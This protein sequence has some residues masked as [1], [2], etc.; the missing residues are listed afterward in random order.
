MGANRPVY[1]VVAMLPCLLVAAGIWFVMP[2]FQQVFTNFNAPLPLL[3][4]VVMATHRWWA[5]SALLP[6][7]VWSGWPPT[8]DR[9]AAAV[10]CGSVLAGVMVTVAVLACYLPIFQLAA[11]V[12]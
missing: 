10:A 2:Q 8:R 6:M 12:G 9:A 1:L 11:A 5:L 7:A 4:A 3:T